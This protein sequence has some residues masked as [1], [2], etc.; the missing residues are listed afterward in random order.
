MD[1]ADVARARER[2]VSDRHG[3]TGG[4]LAAFAFG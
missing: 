3:A 4:E 1:E 2:N